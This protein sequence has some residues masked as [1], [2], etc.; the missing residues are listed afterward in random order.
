MEV[1][2][3]AQ[4]DLVSGGAKTSTIIKSGARI[5]AKNLARGF[6]LGSGVG[7]VAAVVW[8]AADVYYYTKE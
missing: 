2:N 7:T 8:F 4:I 3:D 6:L 1:L 5:F